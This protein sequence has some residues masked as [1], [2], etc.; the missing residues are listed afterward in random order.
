M[1]IYYVNRFIVF[2]LV[3]FLLISVGIVFLTLEIYSFDSG[4]QTNGI[5]AKIP[6]CGQSDGSCEGPRFSLRDN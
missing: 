2:L 4:G 6:S 3:L 1:R 5:R